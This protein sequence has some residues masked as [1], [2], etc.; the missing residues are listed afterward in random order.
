MKYNHMY[1]FTFSLV[2]GSEN[3]EGTT[4]QEVRNAIKKRLESISDSELLE[5]IGCPEDTYEEEV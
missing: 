5:C 1:A 2:N 4:P 3:G